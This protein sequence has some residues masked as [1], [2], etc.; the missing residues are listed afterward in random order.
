MNRYK[1]TKQLGDGTYGSVLKAVN[2]TSGEVVAVKK[3]KK[4]FYTW[5]E[6][7]QL[8]EVKSLK[9]L[10]HPNI[11]KLKEVIREND[12]LFFVFEFMENNLY[13]TMKKRDRH[14]PESKIRNLMYQ[15]L[16]GLAFMHKHSFFHRDIKPENMLVKGDVVKV[17]D[18]GLAREI[19]SRPPFTDYVSTRWYRAPEVLL[20]STTYNS[21]ID[22]WAMGCIMAEM[23]TLRPL[24][25]GSSE[26]DQIYKICSVLGNPTHA[27][28]PEGMKLA[29]Q[30]NY[31][32][33][34]FVPTSLQSII[35]HASPEAI[36]LMQDFMKYD[37][38]QRPT[39]SQAL[40]YPFF[41]VNV[42]IPA[43][44]ST[45]NAPPQP[46]SLAGTMTPVE[47]SPSTTPISSKTPTSNYGPVP[48]PNYQQP[49]M[50]PF[51][52]AAFRTNSSNALLPNTKIAPR[53]AI[54]AAG[55]TMFGTG[56]ALGPQSGSV[57][58][59]GQGNRYARQARYAPGMGNSDNNEH[60]YGAVPDVLSGGKRPF[61]SSY[62]PNVPLV[63]K[64]TT[65]ASATGL[66]AQLYSRHNF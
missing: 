49:T 32:F 1:V 16:Q 12:E 51:N 18:F 26:G 7:M 17:A 40:Q 36:Q 30:M 6:C 63:P 50:D 37:P 8:R 65:T 56:D 59:S 61:Q 29:A 47:K 3:M 11:I 41:Q 60:A 54:A 39:S 21:P 15:M 44:L 57:D 38:N 23:F 46:T 27:T 48:P 28:W 9:K 24:F 52:G 20:R 33:P 25:P 34:Q 10:N 66:G 64:S 35:P 43:S 4:K 58:P 42:S 55:N 13:E 45:P 22:A 31:R 5:E 53:N 19:R 2:R 62:N 14:F